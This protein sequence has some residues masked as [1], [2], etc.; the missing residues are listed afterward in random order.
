MPDTEQNLDEM[1]GWR[2]IIDSLEKSLMAFHYDIF[3]ILTHASER[4]G[5]NL[6]GVAS[7]A[8]Y[9]KMIRFGADPIRKSAFFSEFWKL[10]TSLKLVSSRMDLKHFTKNLQ[11]ILKITITRDLSIPDDFELQ[12][13]IFQNRLFNPTR[14]T[15]KRVP[16]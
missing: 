11:Q 10:T 16:D 3:P 6:C 2:A 15:N 8:G 13:S 1:F 9:T 14:Q 4:V 12:H 7:A 5:N